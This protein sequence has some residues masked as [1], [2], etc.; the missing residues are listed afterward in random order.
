M[1]REGWMAAGQQRARICVARI[2]AAHGLRGEVRLNSFTAD[3]VAATGYGPLES[4][5]GRRA[6]EIETWRQGTGFLV[7]RFKGI[8]DR[9][10]A[11][12]L[13]NLDLYVSRDRLPKPEPDE[14]YH[15]DLIGLRAIT[16][17][18][19]EIGTVIALHDFGAGDLIEI[20]PPTGGT[21]MMLPFTAAV[22]PKVDIAGGAIVVMPPAVVSDPA[23]GDPS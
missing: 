11:E 4:E 17:D 23:D 1:L 19:N 18:G 20:A 12:R 6:F 21:T 8:A 3:P 5:D 22:V 7:V 16:V 14:F 15:A 13:C 9:T 2:G 10:A